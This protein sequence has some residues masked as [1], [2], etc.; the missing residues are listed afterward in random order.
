ML[1]PRGVRVCGRIS[2]PVGR[3]CAMEGQEAGHRRGLL[4]PALWYPNFG[5]GEERGGAYKLKR[6]RRAP[7]LTGRGGG[8]RR[9]PT[10]GGS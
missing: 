2:P 1:V 8:P 10:G 3:G 4:L 6:T 5:E 7:Q 9:L